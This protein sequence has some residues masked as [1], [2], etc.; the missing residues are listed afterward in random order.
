[1][2]NS[3]FILLIGA[4]ALTSCIGTDIVEEVVVPEEVSITA[5]VEEL[6]V[7]DSFTFAADHFDMF[8]RRSEESIN[9]SS[10]DEAILGVTQD[11]LVTAVS[12]GT[13]YIRAVVGT[14]RDSVL[15][16]AGDA[17]SEVESERSGLFE[18][19]RS[20]R[21]EGMFTLT[22]TGGDNLELTFASD[23]RASNGPGLFIYLSNAATNVNGGIELGAIQS[24]SGAQTYI[25]SKQQAQLNSY[26]HVVVYCKP[27]GVAFGF[28]EFD[29]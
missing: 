12:A 23:F 10:S 18:G 29:D 22:D 3:L 16:E 5:G 20:Y 26:S 15:V 1:M 21:V 14:A 17:T 8:G 9:W 2:K 4:L 7:G 6:R 28:G 24:N 25:I 13:A 19:L 11:G 27:F